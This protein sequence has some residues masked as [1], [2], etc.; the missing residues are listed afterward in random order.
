MFKVI[1]DGC[2]KE[3]YTKKGENPRDPD[4]NEQWYSR[5]KDGVTLH[6]CSRKCIEKV[7]GLVLPI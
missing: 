7:G 3:L 5:E 1:C 6:A 2:S 4:T